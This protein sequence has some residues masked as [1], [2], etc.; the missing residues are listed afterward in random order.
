[1]NTKFKAFRDLIFKLS[2]IGE[3]GGYDHIE[4][5]TTEFDNYWLTIMFVYDTNELINTPSIGLSIKDEEA[6]AFI[7]LD[8][9]YKN[10]YPD[11]I[12]VYN[13]IVREGLYDEIM[14]S[15]EGEILECI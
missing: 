10:G 12:E 14:F 5:T 4:G 1:M 13:K 6:Y 8:E 11:K 15:L 7:Y 3:R 9:F 2:E